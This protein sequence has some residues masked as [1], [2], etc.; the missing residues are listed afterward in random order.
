MEQLNSKASHFH[1]RRLIHMLKLSVVKHHR[2]AKT[3]ED[4][5]TKLELVL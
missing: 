4:L 3:H 2:P 1:L 5:I